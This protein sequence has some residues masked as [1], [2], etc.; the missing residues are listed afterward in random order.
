M[1]APD[2]NHAARTRHTARQNWNP[3]LRLCVKPCWP[4]P[5][6]GHTNRTHRAPEPAS[7]REQAVPSSSRCSPVWNPAHPDQTPPAQQGGK[8]NGSTA[9]CGKTDLPAGFGPTQTSADAAVPRIPRPQPPRVSVHGIDPH[10]L[11]LWTT[12]HTEGDPRSQSFSPIVGR[13]PAVLCLLP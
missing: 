7:N 2:L 11:C 13:K 10:R 6:Y 9:P 12:S 5:C 1:A 3:S 8:P 4:L